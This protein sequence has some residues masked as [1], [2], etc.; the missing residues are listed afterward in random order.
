M[1]ELL[2]H[3]QQLFSAMGLLIKDFLSTDSFVVGI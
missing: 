2:A 1:N 3:S